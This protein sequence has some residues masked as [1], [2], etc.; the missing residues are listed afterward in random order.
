[1]NCIARAIVGFAE[2]GNAV[3]VLGVKVD[4][5]GSYY[6]ELPPR[7]A[8]APTGAVKRPIYV[9]MGGPD[10]EQ[11]RRIVSALASEL[12]DAAFAMEVWPGD[13]SGPRP[14]PV[15]S[16][17]F[18]LVDPKETRRCGST[19]SQ[20]QVVN[21]ENRTLSI[22]RPAGVAQV[23]FPVRLPTEATDSSLTP[24]IKPLVDA[25]ALD[26][27]DVVGG[28]AMWM[29]ADGRGGCF[30]IGPEGVTSWEGVAAI[31]PRDPLLAE[32]ST[33]NDAAPANLGRTLFLSELWQTTAKLLSAPSRVVRLTYLRAAVQ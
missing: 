25:R 4:F 18:R 23:L 27:I 28:R 9:W 16:S 8:F 6:P 12:G 13:W 20:P 5:A 33:R 11:G 17:S 10:V 14:A 7:T 32:W 31:T 30:E 2:R 24:P 3:W 19:D 26:D 29:T 15:T 1:V 22:K 21:I